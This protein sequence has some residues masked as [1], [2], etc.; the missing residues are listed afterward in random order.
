MKKIEGLFEGEMTACDDPLTIYDLENEEEKIKKIHR[1]IKEEYDKNLSRE[2]KIKSALLTTKNKQER[3]KN[4][5]KIERY[6]KTKY[7]ASAINQIEVKMLKVYANM[8]E[9][10]PF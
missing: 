2:E 4:I 1:S 8:L 5:L 3:L 9:D 7:K 6:S 10:I